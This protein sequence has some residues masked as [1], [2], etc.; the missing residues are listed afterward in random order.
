MLIFAEGGKLENPEK[1]IRSK[2]EN[3]Q[4]LSYDGESR[5]RPRGHSGES[6]ALTPPVLPYLF[7]RRGGPGDMVDIFH[8]TGSPNYYYL[9]RRLI[10]S[11]IPG[12]KPSQRIFLVILIFLQL[13][14]QFV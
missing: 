7:M 5:N 10:Y 1:T 3:Q 8:N 11:D 12:A 14:L 4:Q 6:R 9:K 2:G 13:Y